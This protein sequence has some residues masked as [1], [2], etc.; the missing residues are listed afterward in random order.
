MAVLMTGR[1]GRMGSLK[2]AFKCRRCA[3]V[4][5][6]TCAKY[7]HDYVGR[8]AAA[9]SMSLQCDCGSTEFEPLPL[10]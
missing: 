9:S 5:C 10:D 4:Y 1:E 2:M 8:S 6:Q 7:K 3:K